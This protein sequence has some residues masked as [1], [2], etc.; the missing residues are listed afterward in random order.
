MKIEEKKTFRW[1][2][3]AQES[4]N[5]LSAAKMIT[6]VGDRENDFYEFFSRAPNDRFHILVRSRGIRTVSDETSSDGTKMKL[7]DL[8]ATWEPKGIRSIEIRNF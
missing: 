2:S 1:I 5:T 3:A 4:F 7:R 6:I 8:V